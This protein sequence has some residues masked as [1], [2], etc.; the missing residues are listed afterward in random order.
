MLSVQN[1]W[2]RLA[3]V[4]LQILIIIV[5]RGN[6]KKTLFA[7][8]IYFMISSPVLE[9]GKVHRMFTVNVQNLDTVHDVIHTNIK[10]IKHF[11][12]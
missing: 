12:I 5:L 6:K 11:L 3:V 1:Y 7:W 8:T 4:T 9:S 10:K 2:I